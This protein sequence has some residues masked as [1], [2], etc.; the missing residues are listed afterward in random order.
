M[1]G[2]IFIVLD[3]LVSFTSCTN[4]EKMCV[5]AAMASFIAL[6]APF[7]Y[8]ELDLL[9]HIAALM[10]QSALCKKMLMVKNYKTKLN[11]PTHILIYRDL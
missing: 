7:T 2:V 1:S 11:P 9:P 6:T 3:T 4:I 5:T 10:Q 8:N